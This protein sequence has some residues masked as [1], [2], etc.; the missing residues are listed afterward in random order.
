MNKTAVDMTGEVR[1]SISEIV[2]NL[3][4]TKS[5]FKEFDSNE[6]SKMLSDGM[7]ETW[8]PEQVMEI[9]DD[10]LTEIMKD[11]MAF[12]AI[13]GLLADFTPEEMEIFDAAVAGR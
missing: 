2:S 4:Q 3:I 11:I 9:H 7:L 8:S 1:T 12:K 6:M 13:S 10:E 5:L